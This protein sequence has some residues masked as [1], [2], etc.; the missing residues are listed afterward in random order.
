[1]DLLAQLNEEQRLAV[2]STDGA[3]LV[4]A[5]AG[6]GK[7]RVLVYKIAHIL[8]TGRAAADEIIAVTFTNKAA[9]EMKQRVASLLG[10][11]AP[12]ARVGTFH[13]LCLR[14]LRREAH[15]LGYADGFQV[16]DTEDAL[17]LIK[18]CIKSESL[19]EESLPPRDAL[20]RISGAKNKAISPEEA[21]RRWKL[22]P[23]AAA[24]RLYAAYEDRLRRMNAMDF[25]DLILNVLRLFKEHPDRAALWSGACRYLLVDEYQDTNPPQYELIRALSAAHG[26]LSV[27]GDEDQAIYRFRGADIGNIL[28][29][30]EDFPGA[31]VI[32]LTRNYRSTGAILEAANSLVRHNKRRIGKELWT[33]EGKGGKPRFTVLP[34]D[35]E[36]ATFVLG[37]IARRR[38]DRDSNETGIL[39]RTNA[40]SRLFEEALVRA[41]IPYRIYGSVRFY[42][43]RE[44]RDLLAYLRL[45]LNPSDD[46]S[47]RRVLNTPTRG[48]GGAAVEAI[49]TAARAGATSLR[50]GLAAALR[51]EALPKRA[52]APAAAFLGLIDG[53]RQDASK[54][55]AA[56]LLRSVIVETDYEAWVRKAESEEAESR[57]ENVDQLVAAAGEASDSGGLQ[58]FLDRSALVNDTDD[59]KGAGGPSLMTLHSAKGLEFDSVFLVGMEEGLLPHSRTLEAEEEIE[60]E[61]RLCYVGLTRARSALHLTAAAQRR[62]YGEPAPTT[63]SRF[64]AEIG[65]DQLAA[66]AYAFGRR[67]HH[68]ARETTGDVALGDEDIDWTEA[69]GDRP[70]GFR[71]GLRVRHASFGIGEVL[72]VEP[73]RGG[74]KL[75]VRFQGGRVRKLMT[76]YA[77]LTALPPR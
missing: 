45:A 51:A 30:K 13:S 41:G 59:V 63:I 26:N 42:E 28:S 25:D 64:V 73:A 10:M 23:A 38:G 48:L 69:D 31:E 55:S 57:L 2:E 6:S 53:L 39:Y 20:R 60:E 67:E 72:Q 5:G 58:E 49:E 70:A 62:L 16:C 4:L 17:R 24:A 47:F 9:G 50:E 40:Q 71:P 21:S 77:R 15:R 3:V 65:E 52:A 18:D 61:R 14:L 44:I 22:P 56:E 36:E 34:G 19:D 43:R 1:M 29:F 68:S 35:R 66:D 12:L 54:V 33:R 37:E 76:P 8:A 74:Q 7:T 27:V 75:T 11:E 46:V 32:K